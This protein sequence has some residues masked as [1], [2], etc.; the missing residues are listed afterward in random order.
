MP[1]IRAAG[2][3]NFGGARRS[4]LLRSLAYFFSGGW[5]CGEVPG[6]LLIGCWVWG[7]GFRVA[8]EAM[9]QWKNACPRAC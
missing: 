6:A 2:C 7:F 1:L 9:Q 3:A 4:L 5:L 8:G